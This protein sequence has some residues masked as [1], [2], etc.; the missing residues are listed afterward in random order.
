MTTLHSPFR[1]LRLFL[2]L[3]ITWCGLEAAIQ[4]ALGWGR[5]GHRVSA[6]LA[7]ARLSPAARAAVRDLLEPG[8]SLA[9]ASTWAD[10][11]RR[12]FPESGPWHYVNVPITESRYDARFCPQGGCVV[13]KIKD[14]RLILADR[15]ASRADRQKALR[16]LTHFV[17]DMHQPVHVG[18][19]S[20]RGG[21]DLQLQFFGRGSN[22][23]RIW[24]SGLIEHAY[25]NEEALFQ[26]LETAVGPD[27]VR[28]WEQG[29]VEDWANE[30]FAAAQRAYRVPGTELGLK[31][32]MKLGR[33][34]EE[35]HL[36]V[37]R[38]R[39]HQ[40]GVRL[41]AILNEIF[42]ESRQ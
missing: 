34:Y 35:L 36:P 14:F 9:D 23:H 40:S 37:A 26:T 15:D 33:E 2:T 41:A 17:Q 8:E 32:G 39:V 12:D 28:L 30:S 6:R 27:L 29:T 19:R 1:P 22:L 11:H 13:S 38:M 42:R 20:D 5:I 31:A 25:E 4:P 24:D 18:E 10:E 7:E 21:N 16:F 3:L